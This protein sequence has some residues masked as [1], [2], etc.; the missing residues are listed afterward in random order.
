MPPLIKNPR[1]K[2]IVQII[3]VTSGKLPL[4]NK[5]FVTLV[6]GCFGKTCYLGRVVSPVNSDINALGQCHL[7]FELVKVSDATTP[8]FKSS[9]TPAD[10]VS[11][12][13]RYRGI[14]TNRCRVIRS[15][16]RDIDRLSGPVNALDRK[17]I[18]GN[19][20]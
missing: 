1:Y 2:C 6:S 8:E 11:L 15:I 10:V 4:Q 13:S 18:G 3:N 20:T 12:G 14:S 16:D 7:R 5:G 9:K 17:R 19:I